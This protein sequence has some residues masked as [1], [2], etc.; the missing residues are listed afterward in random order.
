MVGKDVIFVWIFFSKGSVPH[1]LDEKDA[2]WP[3]LLR[4]DIVHRIAPLSG[5]VGL[6]AYEGMEIVGLT[7]TGILMLCFPFNFSTSQLRDWSRLEG[8]LPAGLICRL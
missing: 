4:S 8:P 2:G 7:L 3:H 5:L 1:P 6:P